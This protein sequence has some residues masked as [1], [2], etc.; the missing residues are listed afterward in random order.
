MINKFLSKMSLSL[1][2]GSRLTRKWFGN[3]SGMTRFTLVSLICLCMLT[4]GVGNAWGQVASQ[5]PTDGSS[6]VVT[7]YNNSKYYAIPNT[8]T[9][10]G[11]LSG[12]QV[13]VNASGQVTSDNPPVWT[14]EEGSTSGQFYLKFT[15]G[16]NT[17]YLYKNGTN[18]SNKNFAVGTTNKNYW[19]F[20]TSGTGYNA[21][22]VNRGSN[23][24][25]IGYENNAFCC[26]GTAIVLRLLPVAA[27][28]YSIT[29][30]CNGATS[31]CPSDASG[32]T[33]LPNSLQ[34][35]A[36][37]G[38]TFGGW[39]TDAAL[40]SA[41]S[42]G[43]TLSANA[44]LYA[45]WTCNVTLNRNGATET[46][47]NV[48]E[49]TTLNSIDGDGDQGGCSAWTFV[50]WSKTQRAAQ[51]VSTAMT[52][53]TT[54]DGAGPYYAVYSHTEGGGGSSDVTDV[55][56][57]A[58]VDATGTSYVAF[59]DLAG[60]SSDAVYAGQSA[61]NGSDIQLRA[62]NPAGIVSTTSGGTVKSVVIE[63]SSS[64]TDS[65]TINVYGK[66]TAYSTAADLYNSSTYGTNV[67]SITYTSSS[68]YQ[69]TYNF[70]ADYEYVGIRMNSSATRIAS[71]SIT[72]TT[73]GGGTTYYS[74]TATCCTALGT[75]NGSFF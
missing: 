21:T 75:I 58:D 37:T 10:G 56:T 3:D 1:D 70:A 43:A 72:W 22:A 9:G 8:I 40:T 71:I 13:T 31:G 52:L 63:W 7:Y 62:T 54:V 34:T 42:A 16:E 59:E 19:T 33:A 53:V 26:S 65:R 47:N 46:I 39:Y 64:A 57:A 25:K 17:Y 67:G 68:N 27:S 73:S 36:K 28:G 69:T 32:Q 35:P 2:N 14:F 12:T 15:S 44:D 66:S 74:T 60:S 24:T 30:H 61:K 4:V 18:S 55:I 45:K 23:R 50:G 49:G 38:F 6:Y 41:A 20:A 11:T 48:T 5:A 29:Y 51:N